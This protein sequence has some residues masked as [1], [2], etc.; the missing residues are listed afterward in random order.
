MCSVRS[1]GPHRAS[2]SSFHPPVAVIPALDNC[3]FFANSLRA[4]R[5]RLVTI[6]TPSLLAAGHKSFQA[7]G[8]IC[9]TENVETRIDSNDAQEPRPIEGGR[10]GR[11]VDIRGAKKIDGKNYTPA[12]AAG[13]LGGRAPCKHRVLGTRQKKPVL[14]LA[15][16]GCLV[17]LEPT[18]FRTTI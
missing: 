15:F 8:L 2:Q 5:Y 1:V 10:M 9:R 3:R 17:G 13:V 14:R 7:S 12:L 6:A 16:V 11:K 4:L 18:T